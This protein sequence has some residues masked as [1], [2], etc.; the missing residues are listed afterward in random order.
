[1]NESRK[2][3]RQRLASERGRRNVPQSPPAPTPDVAASRNEIREAVM[4]ALRELCEANRETATLFLINGYSVEDI[5]RFT[6]R[7]LGT[8]KRRLHDARKQ[9]QGAL[10]TMVE[11]DLKHARPGKEFTRGVVRRIRDIHVGFWKREQNALLLTD[12][13]NRSFPVIIGDAEARAIDPWVRGKASIDDLDLHTTIIRSLGTFGAS[14]SDVVI[15]AIKNCTFFARM[16]VRKGNRWCTIDCRPSDALNLAVRVDAPIYVAAKV[17]DQM[18]LKDSQGKPIPPRTAVRD[19]RTLVKP[20]AEDYPNGA[21]ALRVLELQ[22]GC[23]QARTALSEISGRH[24]VPP[25]IR[26]AAQGIEQVEAW[27]K[28]HQGTPLEAVGLGLVG[29]THLWG[30]QR[31]PA[32]ALPY[33]ERAYRLAPSDM[34]LALDLATAYALLNRK[35]EALGLLR[36]HDSLAYKQDFGE[37]TNFDS[38]RCTAWF[39]KHTHDQKP[40][41]PRWF[42][43]F[44]FCVA[45]CERESS[46]PPKGG[47]EAEDTLRAAPGVKTYPY[48]R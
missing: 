48:P 12:A 43:S 29:A 35:R 37:L 14:I 47:A 28:R 25:R 3:I 10:V 30:N 4:Q 44:Q 22:P 7:P 15:T 41:T 16:R 9:L 36:K 32:K 31:D 5:S 19:L 34:P 13:D 8:V 26:D 27:A 20:P 40:D 11:E 2:R 33:L 46:P 45:T 17:V 38:L 18:L 24:A 21:A 42:M 1:M 23:Q 39:R 6:G